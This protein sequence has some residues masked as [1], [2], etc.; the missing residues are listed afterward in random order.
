MK[1]KSKLILLFVLFFIFL[2]LP[3]FSLASQVSINSKAAILVEPNTGKILFEKNSTKKMYPA[4]TTKI[5]TAILVLENSNLSDIVTVSST[6][7]ENI[8]S[9]YVT[10]QLQVG[11]ELSVENLL[12]ALMVSSAN[13]AAYVL[14]EYIGN[15]VDGFSAMMN[16]KALEIGCLNTHFVNP[17]GIHDEAHY[18]TAYDLYLMA[19]YAMEN[20]T[21]RKLVSTTTYTL[22]ITNKYSSEDRILQTTNDLI[23]PNSKNYYYKYAI[24]IKT[25]YTS[26]AGNCLVSQSSRDGLDFICVTLGGS[27]TSEGLNARY[28]DSK[29]LLNYAYDNFTV[30]KI[31]EK[32]SVIKTIEV[33]NATKETKNLDLLIEDSITVVNHKDTKTTDI[34]PDIKLNENLLAPITSGQIIGTIKYTVDD[35]EYSS[36]LLA[37]NDVIPKADI[38]I[39]LLIAGIFILFIGIYMLP[40]KKQKRKKS[41][42]RK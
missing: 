2:N 10:C 29:K 18:S 34:L 16:S 15:S 5:M 17:N 9:G 14:A 27:A 41:K 33:E 7:L 28:V 35:V 3:I 32:N 30:S 25:G 22:P 20:E 23:K 6:A 26:E 1:L 24:G 39:Y 21:F 12:Y 38:S 42:R 40:N 19:K 8:P 37:G 4:S 36:N 13:D 11:E 31:T